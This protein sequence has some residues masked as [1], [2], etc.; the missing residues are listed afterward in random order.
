MAGEAALAVDDGV[1][2]AGFGGPIVDFVQEGDDRFLVGDGYVD[3]Q[4]TGLAQ[5]VDEGAHV[6]GGYRVGDIPGVNGAGVQG[7]LLEDGRQG[8]AD[9]V[10]DDAEGG[11]HF[12]LFIHE[13]TRSGTND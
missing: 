12:S 2:G 1:D 10:A 8:V 7:R 5:V 3:A 9:G 13:E 6:V 4:D 11:L